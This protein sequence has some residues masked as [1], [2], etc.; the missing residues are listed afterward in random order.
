M[1]T[2]QEKFIETAVVVHNNKYLYDKVTYQTIHVPVTITCPTHGDFV[3]S[4]N[5]HRKGMGCP[6][7]GKEKQKKTRTDNVDLGLATEEWKL[8]AVKIHGTKYNYS[9]VHYTHNKTKVPITC[10]TCQTRFIQAP[11][12]HLQGHGCP[13]C[14]RRNSIAVT[15]QRAKLHNEKKNS[16]AATTSK[17][18]TTVKHGST[19]DYSKTKY[20]NGKTKITVICP[21]HGE[22]RQAP[23]DHLRGRGCPTCGMVQTKA[24]VE[25][26]EYLE[27]LDE[28]VI[29]RY[30]DGKELDLFLPERNIGIEYNGLYWHSELYKDRNYHADKSAYF[31]AKGVRVLHV[32]EDEWENGK[33][34]IQRYLRHQLGFTSLR[35]YAR[36]CNVV[37]LQQKEANVV[38]SEHHLQG[39]TRARY[40]VGLVH[41]STNKVVAVGAFSVGASQRGTQNW[42]LLRYATTMSVPGGLG[43][44][45]AGFRRLTGVSEP[46]TSYVHLDKFTGSAYAKAGFTKAADLP[47]DYKTF[48][49]KEYWRHS[50]QYSRRSNLAQML[51]DKFNSTKTEH[52]NCLDNG[53]LRVYDAGK[54]KWVY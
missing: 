30:R 14:A 3:Q 1:K 28:T 42:E 50:K 15:K 36:Q 22:F 27:G 6:E 10:N 37:L 17:D 16:R 39:A 2:P 18:R 49:Q 7:C 23:L 38:L 34:K 9:E 29:H 26:K 43:K 19:Y 11:G 21:V 12:Y 53:L 8:K 4:P 5:N 13:E 51:G 44:V 25:L 33:E 48:S 41:R 20:A 45:M 47:P 35:A 52:Q 54:S 40:Y 31:A 32:W 46:I 24:E